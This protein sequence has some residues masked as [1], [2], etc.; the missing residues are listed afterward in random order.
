[1]RHP[2]RQQHP[3]RAL[4]LFLPQRARGQGLPAAAAATGPRGVLGAGL[5]R[6]LAV[7]VFRAFPASRR[8]AATSQLPPGVPEAAD[9]ASDF[10]AGATPGPR[11]ARVAGCEGSG[12]SAR[13]EL[14]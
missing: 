4:Q 3:T 11:G 5:E 7:H 14:R 13:L 8:V 6:R 12:L 10:R 2:A 9:S 1:M